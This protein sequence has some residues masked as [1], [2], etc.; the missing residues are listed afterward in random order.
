MVIAS[1]IEKFQTYLNGK[2]VSLYKLVNLKGNE[3]SLT[4]YGARIISIIVPDKF[5]VKTDVV[6]GFNSIEEYLN[7]NTYQGAAVGRFANRIAFG[8]FKLNG[9][10]YKISQNL[11]EHCL[12]GGYEGFQSK[13]WDVIEQGDDYI[14]MTLFCPDGEDGFPGNLNVTCSY[15]LTINDELIFE[16]K[17]TSDA[18]T[19]VNFTQHNYFNLM[20][21][22]TGDI[23]KHKLKIFSTKYDEQVEGNICISD[24]VS[25][26]GTPFDFSGEKLI[27]QDIHS[28]HPQMRLGHG[29]DHNY[30]INDFDGSVKL[31]ASVLADNGINLKVKSNQPCCQLYTFNWAD[32]SQTGKSGNKY[33]KFGAFCL[34]PQLAPNAPNRPSFNKSVLRK[35][36]VFQTVIIH[37]FGVEDKN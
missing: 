17:A 22:G 3:V 33:H 24:P 31:V 29:Y 18:D 26:S 15:R 34:E 9:Q 27:G 25:V 16:C 5:G 7:D 8:K 14:E 2:P 32:G 28:S 4:N 20:G 23:L 30:H 21:E 12:H 36:E 1:D 13:V 19:V 10:E 35:G 37:S 6:L 11:G